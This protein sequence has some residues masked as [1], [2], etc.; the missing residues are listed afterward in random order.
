M[1]GKLLCVGA[2]GSGNSR[3]PWR[4]CS[5]GGAGC[6]GRGLLGRALWPARALGTPSYV[7]GRSWSTAG[8]TG[9][10]DPALTL[11]NLT[12]SQ[13]CWTDSLSQ[14]GLA[15]MVSG[16]SGGS[17]RGKCGL[18]LADCTVP[19][20]L[21]LLVAVFSAFATVMGT[22]GRVQGLQ[23]RRKALSDFSRKLLG[24]HISRSWMSTVQDMESRTG[25]LCSPQVHRRWAVDAATETPL[26]TPQSIPRVWV[27]DPSLLQ[28]PANVLPGRP[29]DM[30]F[31]GKH[32]P[33]SHLKV[34][35]MG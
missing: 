21:G 25:T 27:Q 9:P 14:K 24:K 28:L 32:I 6:V 35:P 15:G 8:A 31:L 1:L 22:T 19:G 16:G 4:E 18:A 3:A 30:A 29:R 23:G 11:R 7:L 17:C 5:T 26:G 34:L 33:S 2:E 10:D 20:S 13:A 12:D